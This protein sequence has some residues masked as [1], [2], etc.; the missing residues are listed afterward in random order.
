M[1]SAV[2]A[3]PW[4]LVFLG[5]VL[6]SDS[7]IAG[8]KDPPDLEGDDSVE[9][10]CIVWEHIMLTVTVSSDFRVT[11]P[12][13]SREALGIQAGDRLSVMQLGN[14]ISLVPIRPIREMRGS[15]QGIDTTVERDPDRV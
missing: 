8:E 12:K 15:L 3:S 14:R 9:A 11:I 10:D 7:Y 1:E 5:R 13:E 4:L 6:R 2:G